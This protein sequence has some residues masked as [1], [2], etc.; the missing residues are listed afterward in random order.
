MWDLPPPDP[1]VAI[2][3]A[4]RGMSKGLAQKDGVQVIPKAYLQVGNVQVGGQW[5]NVTSPVA[6]GEAA[7][8]VTYAPKIGPYQLSIGGA[9]KFQTKLKGETDDKSW[10]FTGS[11]SR[12]FG[13]LTLKASAVYSPDD[14]G[15]SRRSL[16]L[17]GGPSFEID[18]STRVSANIGRRNR[19]AGVDYTSFNA[20]I[21]KTLFKKA[22][23]DLRYYD[24]AQSDLGEI[25]HGRLVLSGKLAL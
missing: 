14:L 7:A 9:Y 25:Y 19:V 17:E 5:K 3:V 12:K 13:K 10:E 18:G 24:T 4:S 2:H 20:G 15:G 11:A 1:G 16:Y 8:F 21:S 6:D 22:T 23:F